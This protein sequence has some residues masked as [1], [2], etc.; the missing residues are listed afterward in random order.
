MNK[1]LYKTQRQADYNSGKMSELQ[2]ACSHLRSKLCRLENDAQ[3]AE[4][5]RIRLNLIFHGMPEKREGRE[6]VVSVMHEVIDKFYPL[7]EE[8]DGRIEFM[9]AFRLGRLNNRADNSGRV[10]AME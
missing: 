6:N 3:K 1:A 2:N 10:Q 8:E 7:N 5:K 9:N 4:E